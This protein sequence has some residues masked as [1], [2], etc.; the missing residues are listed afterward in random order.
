MIDYNSLGGVTVRYEEGPKRELLVH[1][2]SDAELDEHTKSDVSPV[3][4]LQEIV[5]ERDDSTSGSWS[6]WEGV[7][8][9]NDA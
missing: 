4:E 3:L 7:W 1:F 5:T 8:K 6:Q 2:Y 9:R